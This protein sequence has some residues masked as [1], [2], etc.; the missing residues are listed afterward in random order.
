MPNTPKHLV[1]NKLCII[2]LVAA[3][4]V[5][6][7]GV[8]AENKPPNPLDM[9]QM[10]STYLSG[11]VSPQQLFNMGVEGNMRVPMQHLGVRFVD[12]RTNKPMG[13]DDLGQVL[14]NSRQDWSHDLI[15]QTL[16]TFAVPQ[17]DPDT[18]IDIFNAAALASMRVPPE[19]IDIEFYDKR[20]GYQGKKSGG[21]SGSVP[22]KV[23]KKP[24]T[25]LNDW[26]EQAVIDH[27]VANKV[28]FTPEEKNHFVIPFSAVAS[29]EFHLEIDSHDFIEDKQLEFVDR[30]D[31]FYKYEEVGFPSRQEGRI[32]I[33]LLH[34]KTTNTAKAQA[35]QKRYKKLYGK[36]KASNK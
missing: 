33:G 26:D 4:A 7:G 30:L 36:K 9:M 12:L 32:F 3:L 16:A 22:N 15:R 5:F 24:S 14:G 8:A 27:F 6:S 11:E 13:R 10:M 31:P 1:V 17:V 28:F 29:N 18:L 21:I 20:V 2:F 23:Y 19:Y 34:L 35:M 25:S